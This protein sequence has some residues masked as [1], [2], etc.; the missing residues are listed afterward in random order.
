MKAFARELLWF[1]IA[2]LL[3]APLA[4]IFGYIMSLEPE[5]LT[6]TM[7][8]EVFQMELFI[9]GGIVGFFGTYLIRVIIWAV[10]KHLIKDT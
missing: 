1:F 9:V 6:L 10:Y 3:S 7:Q 5:G 4:Y 2:I 8:E